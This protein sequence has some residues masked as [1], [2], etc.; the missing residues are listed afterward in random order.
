MMKEM[1]KIVSLIIE[2]YR[3]NFDKLD[4]WA[5]AGI[6]LLVSLF[7]IVITAVIKSF[8]APKE[9][10][11]EEGFEEPSAEPEEPIE[12]TVKEPIEETVEALEEA[13]PQ[14]TKNTSCLEDILGELVTIPTDGVKEI[15]IK[16][17]GAEVK[18][19]YAN[20]ESLQLISKELVAKKSNGED[21]LPLELKD[22]EASEELE[23]GYCEESHLEED[24][25]EGPQVE[26]TE[27]DDD[28][29]K[30]ISKFGPGNMNISKSGRVYS[31]AEL[32]EQIKD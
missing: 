1:E 23:D 10:P 15:E 24:E 19:T 21:K 18:V 17:K 5:I 27:E 4:I 11:K 22:V 12:E 14:I 7:L 29:G 13:E 16:I 31:E 25:S 30:T 26:E 28:K 9:E 8:F 20:S 32:E 2:F 6:A 3:N